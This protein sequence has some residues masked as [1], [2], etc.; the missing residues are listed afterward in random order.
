[1]NSTILRSPSGARRPHRGGRPARLVGPEAARR[2]G[3]LA[4]VYAAHRIEEEKQNSESW[5]ET[6][7][8]TLGWLLCPQHGMC[9]VRLVTHDRITLG[10]GCRRLCKPTAPSF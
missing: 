6:V 5:R 4:K 7:R 10:C 2:R 3:A 8:R 9:K 1:M